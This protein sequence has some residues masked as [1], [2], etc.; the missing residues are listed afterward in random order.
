TAARVGA[1]PFHVGFIGSTDTHIAAA[2]LVDE[3][4]HPGHGGAAAALRHEGPVLPDDV[5]YNPGGL[6]GLWAEENSR[7]PPFPATRRGATY[8]TRGPRMVVRVFGGWDLPANSCD[9]PAFVAHGYA[10][11]VPMGGDLPAPSSGGAP[12]FAISA[13]RDAGTTLRP[14]VPLQRV[15]V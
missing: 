2:G 1:N 13:L 11:G 6:A 3:Q 4:G 14:G 8:A 9:D 5:E 7:D 12:R 15:Q 10:G